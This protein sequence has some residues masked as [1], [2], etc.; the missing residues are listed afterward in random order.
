MTLGTKLVWSWTSP[1]KRSNCKSACIFSYRPLLIGPYAG[2]QMMIGI[3]QPI[4]NCQLL[5]C[6]IYIDQL[7]PIGNCQQTNSQ[8][9]SYAECYR[10]CENWLLVDWQLGKRLAN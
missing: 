6:R 2:L 7:L 3:S 5:E 4:G 9:N 10:A 8:P 1:G